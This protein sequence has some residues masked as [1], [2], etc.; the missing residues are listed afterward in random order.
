MAAIQLQATLPSLPSGWSAE[1]D[2]KAVS[3]LSQPTSRA[4]EAVGPHFLAHAR[5][6]RHKRTFSEDERIQAAS[7]AKKTEDEDDGE[8]S[9]P[10]DPMLLQR[11]AKD[12]KT[13]DHYAVLGLS[14][15]R[16]R[17]SEEEIKK[18]HR[19]K[20]LK[21]HPDKKAASG[22]EEN[23]QFFKCIQRATDILLDPIKRRQFDSVD[24]NADKEPPSKKEVQKKPGNFYKLFGPV[25]ESEGRFSKVQPVPQLG[26]P[27]ASREHVEEFYNFWYNFDSW[28]SFEYL[29][30]DV[31]DDNENRDQKRHQERKNLNAR[32][33]RKV[34]DTQRLRK[35][36]DDTMAQD[37]RIK[38]F[39][40]EGNKEKNKKRLEKE[41]AEKAAK[42]EAQRKKEEEERL[43]KEKDASDKAAKEESKKAKEAAKNAAKKNKRV[44]RNAAK[45]GNY[46]ADG[47][48]S[49]QQIDQA[50]NDTDAL[51]TKLEV[52][53]IATMTNN[54]AGKKGADVKN[55]FVQENKRL[56]EAGK[57]KE[58]ELKTF[59]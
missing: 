59:S 22:Q 40:Q 8:I 43:Q 48:P 21:H 33:K 41:A 52:D 23:D 26:G 56:V 38:K 39:R 5:R 32:K 45:D 49:P 54:L 16:W 53:E 19:K 51:I 24:E 35:L 55:V 37:E 14:K 12:W 20:V 18:A 58:G 6:K 10:E 28:R 1:K 34:E 2:F 30:E 4:I 44:I 46:F 9:E 25:F 42:E 29:D 11:E 36:L 27:D 15:K 7:S 31:P 47:E 13:Q 57:A 50:L 17:A 3:T